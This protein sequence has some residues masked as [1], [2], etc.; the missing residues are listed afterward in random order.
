MS[1]YSK[2]A[3]HVCKVDRALQYL[4]EA[5]C[6]ACARLLTRWVASPSF[7]NLPSLFETPFTTVAVGDTDD[8]VPTLIPTYD[9]FKEMWERVMIISPLEFRW[10]DFD[11]HDYW[12]VDYV[13]FVHTHMTQAVDM[14]E[15]DEVTKKSSLF[16]DVKF[17]LA[18]LENLYEY[19]VNN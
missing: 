4:V 7:V 10:V 9:V 6:D 5:V 13:S 11:L 12:D 18:T 17:F 2:Q 8:Q 16:F 1:V 3:C 15:V 19:S 14:W